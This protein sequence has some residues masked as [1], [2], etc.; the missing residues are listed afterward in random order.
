[1]LPRHA[2]QR[3]ERLRELRARRFPG[4]EASPLFEAEAARLARERQRRGGAGDAWAA[5]CPPELLGRT[6]ILGLR[7]G[8]LTIG[9]ADAPTRFVLRNLLASGGQRELARLAPTTIRRVKLV[10]D[11]SAGS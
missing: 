6:R 2:I 5:V 7:R 3:L 11:P 1:M 9:V 10:S 8:A 4:G